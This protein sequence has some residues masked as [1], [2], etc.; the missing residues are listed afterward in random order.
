[1]ILAADNVSVPGR[2]EGI[3]AVLKPRTLTAICGPN[4]A[5][6]T[7]LLRVLAGL[8][9]GAVTLGA[10][11]LAAL[12]SRQRAQAIGY[13][14]QHGEAAWNLSVKALVRLGRLPHCTSAAEDEAACEAALAALNCTQLA[15]RPVYALSGGERARVFLARVLAGQPQWI[16]ADEPLASLDLAQTRALLRHLRQLADRGAGVVVVMHS[17]AHAMNHA[18]HVLV[19]CEGR[20]AAAGPADTALAADVIAKVWGVEGQWV[21]PEGARALSL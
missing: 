12:P 8:Q 9:S 6:K 5:G 4:G 17:L 16:L 15:Q 13:L 2:L 3:S 21:G 1:M 14:P 19:L 10:I 20:L 7:T 18:D 11:P